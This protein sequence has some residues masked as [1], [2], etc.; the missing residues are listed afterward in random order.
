MTMQREAGRFAMWTVRGL[1]AAGTVLLAGAMSACNVLDDALN[2]E[3]PSQVPA[4][5]LDDPALA[6][7]LVG[8]V[9]ADFECAL[10]AFIVTGGLL[11]DE[12]YDATFTANRWPVPSRQVQPSDSRYSTFTCAT[13]GVYTPIS[14]ARWSADNALTK[15]E[16]WTDAEVPQRQQKIA[17]VAAYGGYAHILLAELFCTAAIDLSAELQPADVLQRAEQRFT[18]AIEAAQAAG[19][20]SVLNMARV[21][22]ARV[23]LSLGNLQGAASDAE[24]VPAGFSRDATASSISPRRRNRVNEETRLS[25]VSVKEPFRDLT[26][27]GEADTRVPVRDAGR[28]GADAQTPLFQQRKYTDDAES[29]PIATWREAQLIIAEARG[30]QAAVDAINRLRDFHDLPTYGGGSDAEITAQIREERRRELFLE[31]HRIWDIRRLN[32][33]LFPAPGTPFS[34]GGAHGDTNCLPLP[35]VER[36]SNPNLP[37]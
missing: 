37:R 34:K 13:L 19:D 11:G 17:T 29:I 7:L 31:G 2:V 8:G 6:N 1:R 24:A 27:G 33:P 30:G 15:L 23:R 26:V 20:Q 25:L 21:G 32:L 10:G 12:L 9:I 3:A 28:T 35:D 16:A 14:T 36:S 18:R 22:R 5:A 4:S